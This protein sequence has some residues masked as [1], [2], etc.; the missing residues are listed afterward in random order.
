MP[1]VPPLGT[2]I[3]E[4]SPDGDIEP[5]S[6]DDEPPLLSGAELLLSSSELVLSE[7]DGS[8]GPQDRDS[9]GDGSVVSP[10]RMAD[11]VVA[12]GAVSVW[13]TQSEPPAGGV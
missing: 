6:F 2:S 13:L 10:P 5:P 3:E 1:V 12:S 11:S 9:S 8:S 4:D 7:V